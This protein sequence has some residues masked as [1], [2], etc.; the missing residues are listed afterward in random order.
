MQQINH[1]QNGNDV[2]QFS[3]EWTILLRN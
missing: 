2:M 1:G 3:R